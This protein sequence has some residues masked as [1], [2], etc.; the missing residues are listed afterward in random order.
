LQ[1]QFVYFGGTLLLNPV[2]R[3]RQQNLFFQAWHRLLQAFK[4]RPIHLDYCVKLTRDKQGGLADPG[5]A[6]KRCQ[7]PERIKVPV[8]I[9]RPSEPGTLKFADEEVEIRFR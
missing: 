4:H 8:P 9:Q 7:F 3:T 6:E 2:A 5:A 1:E